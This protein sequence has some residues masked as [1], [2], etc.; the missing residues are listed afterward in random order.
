MEQS[1]LAWLRGRQR[2]LPQVALGIG[3]DAA[4][5]DPEPGRQVVLASDGIIDGTDFLSA[6]HDLRQVG[7]KAIAINLSDLAAMGA[8]PTAVL[9]NLSLPETAATEI[10]AEVYE[11]ILAICS[12][13]KLAIAG[14]D[15]SVYAGPLA[16]TVTIVGQVPAGQAW[17]R[18]GGQEGDALLVTGAFGGSLTGRHLSFEPRVATALAIRETAEVHAAMDV[19]DGLSLDLDRLCAASGLG[20]ELD[21]EA[22]PVHPDAIAAEAEGLQATGA[23]R[24]AWSRAMADGEDFE[25]ILSVAP[26]AA[27]RLQQGDLGVP[28]TR[29]GTLTARTGLWLQRRGKLE[30][31]TPSGYV[32]GDR[33][34]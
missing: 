17:R 6:E 32:H 8:E 30:R 23:T 11:G 21:P 9:V 19:S 33:G 18:S 14:G 22:I 27:E 12:D 29:I 7:R 10:A 25:L 34:Q 24:S 26:E 20:A 16:I 5:L 4:L 31:L 28:I 3:D 1:F 15:L 13:Y 2:D